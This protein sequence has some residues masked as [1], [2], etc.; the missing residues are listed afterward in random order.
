[1]LIE[2]LARGELRG[3]GSVC[4]VRALQAVEKLVMLAK[5]LKIFP[6]QINPRTDFMGLSGTDKSVPFQNCGFHGVFPQ[7]V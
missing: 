6:L 1:M 7:R 3:A 2:P 4:R 5:W